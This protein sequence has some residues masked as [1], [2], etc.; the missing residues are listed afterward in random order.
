M[1]T[2]EGGSP[3]KNKIN[4]RPQKHRGQQQNKSGSKIQSEIHERDTEWRISDSDLPKEKENMSK[5]LSKRSILQPSDDSWEVEEDS[6]NSF[7]NKT[8]IRKKYFHLQNIS[9]LE[10]PLE[11]R[12]IFPRPK[13]TDIHVPNNPIRANH[14][15][16][17]HKFLQN[18]LNIHN[19]SREKSL[20]NPELFKTQDRRVSKYIFPRDVPKNQKTEKLLFGNLNQINSKEIHREQE[21]GVGVC[22]VIPDQLILTKR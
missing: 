11:K 17:D 1:Y 16:V 2:W 8:S 6:V 4:R 22:E 14:T 5:K 13:F 3:V 7:N 21:K 18:F 15:F 9:K 19:L 10:D 12:R 20:S